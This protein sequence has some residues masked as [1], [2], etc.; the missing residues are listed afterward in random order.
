L[1]ALIVAAAF[2]DRRFALPEMGWFS[3]AAVAVLSWRLVVDP[4]LNW[5]SYAPMP[6]VLLAFGGVIA[7]LL[8]GLSLIRGRGR[9]LTEGV[10]TSAA[11]GFGAIAANIVIQR[12]IVETWRNGDFTHWGL[13]LHAMPWLVVGLVQL[14]RAGLGGA[15]WIIRLR[16]FLAAAAGIL[17][18]GTLAMAVVGANPLFW[19]SEQNRI[20]GAPFFGSLMLAYFLPGGALFLAALS[21]PVLPAQ[22]RTGLRWLGAGMLAVYAVLSLRQFWH[23]PRIGL[24]RGVMQPELYSYT[25]ALLALGAVLLW[26]A[27]ARRSP[28]LRRLAMGVIAVTV[29]KV[30]FIDIT[31]LTGLTRVASFLGL[32]LA[33]AGLAWLNRWAGQEIDDRST[34]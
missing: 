28:A 19:D 3:Q 16:Y 5:A 25:V 21:M 15:G 12:E 33:L 34:T 8:V 2:L 22:V 23:G 11:W 4:G 13:A 24:E 31:G 7:A 18:I 26:Q 27:L 9:D 20:L 1:A 10:L 32:G 17:A 29:A 14:Y 6:Q 30:F